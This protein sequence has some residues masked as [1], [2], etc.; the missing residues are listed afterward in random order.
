MEKD[1][2]TPQEWALIEVDEIPLEELRTAAEFYDKIVAEG[3]DFYKDK[4]LMPGQE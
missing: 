4:R 2:L 1:K 3:E